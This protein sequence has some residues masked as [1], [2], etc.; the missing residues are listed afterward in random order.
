MSFCPVDKTP[1]VAE[2]LGPAS[3]EVCPACAGVWCQTDQ[4]VSMV[5][6]DREA[7]ADIAAKFPPKVEHHAGG[8]SNLSC[9]NCSQLLREY[10]YMFNSPI[11]LHACERC[12]GVWIEHEQLSKM[13]QFLDASRAPTSAAP[14]PGP[15]PVSSPM[16]GASQPAPTLGGTP[17]DPNP[18]ARADALIA[19]DPVVQQAMWNHQAFMQRHQYVMA[20]ATTL[21]TFAPGWL[22]FL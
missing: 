22:G 9:P 10:H 3:I 7:Y 11:L 6:S 14:S 4:M 15:Q 18:N 2:D 17:F 13:Q 19:Q 12:G 5:R 8:E 16:V 20:L 21:D 1:M